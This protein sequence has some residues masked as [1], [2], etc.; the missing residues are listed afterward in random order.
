MQ[1]ARDIPKD[2]E[3]YFPGITS[4]RCIGKLHGRFHD[5]SKDNGRTG[6]KNDQVHEDSGKTQPVFQTIKIRLQY[7]GNPYPRSNSGKGT[8]QDGTR[9]DKGGERMENTNKSQRYRDFPWICQFLP[10]IHSQL[11]SHSK[12][13]EQVKEQEGMEIGGGTSKGI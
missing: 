3:Q 6:R 4:Q 11:Q 13:I 10:M 8:S 1:L 12:A 7:G 5:T 9:E 2:D